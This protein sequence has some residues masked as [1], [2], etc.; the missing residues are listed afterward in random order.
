[1][2]H[3]CPFDDCVRTFASYRKMSMHIDRR[4]SSSAACLVLTLSSSVPRR[5][6]PDDSL[7][8]AHAQ[9]DRARAADARASK[10]AKR[11]RPQGRVGADDAAIT[12]FPPLP[13]PNLA[14]FNQLERFGNNSIIEASYVL[15]AAPM[16]RCVPD[17]LSGTP[18][19][20][21]RLT[22]DMWERF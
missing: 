14:D 15:Y 22:T 4:A 16:T 19:P 17:F 13:P 21:F 9:L 6:H 7:V 20:L 1:M 18:D 8:Q 12:P 10:R 3:V 2:A 5:E 11:A